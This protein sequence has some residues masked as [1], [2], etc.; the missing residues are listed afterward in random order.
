VWVIGHEIVMEAGNPTSFMSN[1][2]YELFGQEKLGPMLLINI[3][4]RMGPLQ[5]VSCCMIY[6]IP[7]LKSIS[8]LFAMQWNRGL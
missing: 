1:L 6:T 4:H 8:E 7:Q 2:F 5:N 3:E